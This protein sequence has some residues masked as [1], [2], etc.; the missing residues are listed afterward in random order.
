MILKRLCLLTLPLA[1]FACGGSE[2]TPS[3]S[4]TG[5]SSSSSGVGGSGG[6]GGSGG[7]ADDQHSLPDGTCEQAVS[8]VKSAGIAVPRD[9]HETF[10]VDPGPAASRYLF[11]MGGFAQASGKLIKTIER[12]PIADDGSLG[13]WE[14][15]GMLPIGISGAGI[16]LAHNELII[17]GGFQTKSSWT[18]PIGADGSIGAFTEGPLLPGVRF[19]TAGFAYGDYFYLTGGLAGTKTVDEVIRA[20]IGADGALSPFEVTAHL[21]NTLSHHVAIVEGSTL[22]L[23]GGQTGNT[24]DNS[25]L[26]RKEVLVST[27]AED[28]SLGAFTPTAELP[29]SFMATAGVIH[30]DYMYVFGG[31]LAPGMT[32]AGAVPTNKVMRAKVLSPGK[33]GA[34][35][36]DTASALPKARSHVHQTPVWKSHVYSVSGLQGFTDTDEVDIGTFK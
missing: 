22:Y 10:L 26:P 8:W 29:V 12:A 27:I 17:A 3:G 36:E 14:S 5:S 19:H 11:L 15:A 28:G 25:G 34:W 16:A 21:P 35:E 2:S 6:S 30:N 20:K 7:C 1:V 18:A 32:E 23:V 33:L 9:H 24:N 4:A 31:V 13:A